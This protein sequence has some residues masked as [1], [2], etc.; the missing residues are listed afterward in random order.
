MIAENNPTKTL[1][2]RI[3]HSENF[4]KDFRTTLKNKKIIYLVSV[5]KEKFEGEWVERFANLILE[6]EPKEVLI[7]VA[8]SL[9]RFNIEIAENLTEEEAFQKSKDEGQEWVRKCTPYFSDR[10]IKPEFIH[11]EKLKENED[12]QKFFDEIMV[13]NESEIFKRLISDSAK[14]Y[15]DRSDRKENKNQA[16]AQ[17]TKFLNEESAVLRI[18]AKDINTKGLVYPGPPLE[19]FNY[20]I[21]HV[22]NDREKDPFFYIEVSPIKKKNKKKNQ[23]GNEL[24]VFKELP[25]FKCRKLSIEIEGNKKECFSSSKT[26]SLGL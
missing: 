14:A 17:S 15:V 9:Q 11:W 10:G 4:P 8:D 25:F 21:G 5:G 19:I 3:A 26:L 24:N 23:K 6:I 7:V 12:Y 18:L 22:N 13:W 20:I 16:I 1:R 2:F